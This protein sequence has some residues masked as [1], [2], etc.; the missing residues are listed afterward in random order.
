MVIFSSCAVFVRRDGRLQPS[1]HGICML[2][3]LH[4]CPHLGAL[5]M[6]AKHL[7]WR[8]R[9]FK[10]IHPTLTLIQRVIISLCVRDIYWCCK[11]RMILGGRHNLHDVMWTNSCIAYSTIEWFQQLLYTR[12]LRLF[13]YLVI[14]GKKY[15]LTVK[16]N[17][18]MIMFRVMT[19]VISMSTQ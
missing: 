16:Q 19:M 1:T 5:L 9:F 15:N 13:S 7:P 8:R 2:M 11:W 17:F 18:M 3:M 12:L 14:I 6:K 10:M 4:H